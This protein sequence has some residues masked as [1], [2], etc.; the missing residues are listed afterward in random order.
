MTERVQP[1]SKFVAVNGLRLHYLEWGK[2][3]MPV[4]VRDT[5][6]MHSHDIS[7]TDFT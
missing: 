3:E 4:V 6:S 1:T 5:S 2:A 7:R